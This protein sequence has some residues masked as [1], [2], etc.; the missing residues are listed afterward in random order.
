[1][2]Q[3]SSPPSMWRAVLWIF[4]V[5]SIALNAAVIQAQDASPEVMKARMEGFY[6]LQEWHRNGEVVYPPSVDDRIVLLNG[7]IMYMF[8]DRTKEENKKSLAGYGTYLLEPG[9][10]S[11]SYESQIWITQTPSEATVSEKLLWEG[12]RTFV[13]TIENDEVHL[14]ATN[15]PQEFRFTADWMSYGDDKLLRIYRR[16]MDK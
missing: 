14:R 16:V 2:R 5:M 10:F 15:G 13:A 8:H 4:V 12:Q 11:Y 9:K 1:M 6:Q 7:R 3:Q